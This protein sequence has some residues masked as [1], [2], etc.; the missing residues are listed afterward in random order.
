MPNEHQQHVETALGRLGRCPDEQSGFINSPIYRGSTTLYKTL[1]DALHARAP[2][3]YGTHGNP[4]VANLENAWTS[5]TGG[6]GTVL[7]S[8]GM[9][10]VAHAFLSVV[11]AGDNVLVTDTAYFPTRKFCDEFLGKLGVTT[12][13]YDPLITPDELRALLSQSPKTTLIFLESPGSQTFEI[14]DVPGL[15]ATARECGV[16]SVLDNTWATPV[17]FDAHGKGCDISVEA[18]TKYVGGHSDLLL[19]MVS[20]NAAWFPKV[21]ST[22]LLFQC[23]PGNEDC[24]LALRGLRT[25]FIRLKEAEKRALDMARYLSQREEVLRVLHPAF[26]SCPGH[27]LW[28]R[29]FTGSSGLFSVVLIPKYTLADVERMLNGMRLFGMGFSWGGFES[30]IMHYNLKNLRTA[31][32]PDVGGLIVRIQIGLE[33]F[34]DL[35]EDLDAGFGRLRGD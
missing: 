33:N 19:G 28:K 2:F 22:L 34:D 11:K 23:T 21:K 8:S 24:F 13:Y 3:M 7:L 27:L 30:L 29:D 9:A 20:A 15:C 25:M 12:T 26:P 4:T 35:K 14:Q 16:V 17:F 5:L 18:A 10:A 1:D 6:A 32:S 31:T